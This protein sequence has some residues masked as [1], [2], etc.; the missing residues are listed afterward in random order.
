MGEGRISASP[1]RLKVLRTSLTKYPRKYVL[2]RL[3]KDRYSPE[4]AQ[5]QAAVKC[6]LADAVG[7]D[8][9][10]PLQR[11]RYSSHAFAQNLPLNQLKAIARAQRHSLGTMM[12]HERDPPVIKI[13][14]VLRVMVYTKFIK[15]LRK[16]AELVREVA[17]MEAELRPL[18]KAGGTIKQNILRTV[19]PLRM[20]GCCRA[21]LIKFPGYS[22]FLLV[23]P[24]YP[25]ITVE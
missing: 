21:T 1:E 24:C 16:Y 9:N 5:G 17:K 3:L 18:K 12:L 22:F 7:R 13:F 11:V 8:V 4:E 19:L 2:P 15:A 20:E 10:R 23:L 6:L 25:E 14:C